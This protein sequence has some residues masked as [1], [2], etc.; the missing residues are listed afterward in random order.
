MTNRKIEINDFSEHLFWD[1][2]KETFDISKHKEQLIYKVLEY[3]FLKDWNLLKELFGQNEIKK[4]VLNLRSLDPV[5]L[6]FLSTLFRIEKSEF[7][8]YK[9]GK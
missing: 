1:I 6:S 3:G 8:C 7:R 4:V 9:Q 2:N 5:T